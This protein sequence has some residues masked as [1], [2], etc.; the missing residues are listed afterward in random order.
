[1]SRKS[2]QIFFQRRY[3]HGQQVHEKVLNTTNHR[4]N[5]NQNHN[6]I[7]H[8]AVIKKTKDKRWRGCGEKETLCTVDGNKHWYSHCE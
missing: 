8:M 6:E 5:A 2:E 3:T 1:M 7:L 4:E